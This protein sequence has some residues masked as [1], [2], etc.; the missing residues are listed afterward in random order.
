MTEAAA[1]SG[2]KRRRVPSRRMK[3]LLYL[4]PLILIACDGA[5]DRQALCPEFFEPYPDMISGQ[6]R[7]SRNAEYL[8]AMALYSQ[9]DHAEA[10]KGLQAFVSAH[11]DAPRSALLYLAMSQLATG[12]PYDAEL[13]LDK[14]EQSHM[15]D[16]S[17]QCEWY[18]VLCWLCSEQW[19]RALTGAQAIAT[20]QRHTYKQQAARLAERLE[21]A[22]KE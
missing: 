3:R 5:V 12:N 8:D 15:R 7:S 6:A 4:L 2:D 19:D 22:V 18:T 13:T 11:R 9:G 16:F 1:A 20:A 14:L 10:A 17:D 21:R